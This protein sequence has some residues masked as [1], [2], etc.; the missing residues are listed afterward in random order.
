MALKL[1]E[2]VKTKIGWKPERNEIM[3]GQ[4]DPHMFTKLIQELFDRICDL[5]NQ[6][7]ELEKRI[8]ELESKE[9]KE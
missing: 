5:E 7:I 8:D 9:T 4:F 1:K 6:N 3:Q 2:T